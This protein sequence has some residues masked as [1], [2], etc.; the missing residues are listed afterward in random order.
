MSRL[1]LIHNNLK[2]IILIYFGYKIIK[3]KYFIIIIMFDNIKILT[4]FVTFI[5]KLTKY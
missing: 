3:Y 1:G 5:I 2:L 4:I